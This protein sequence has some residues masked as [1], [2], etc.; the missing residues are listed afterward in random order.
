MTQTDLLLL[1]LLRCFPHCCPEHAPRSYCG[2][3]VHLLVTFSHAVG[4]VNLDELEVCTRFEP[5]R[6]APLWTASLVTVFR[7]AGAVGDD[8]KHRYDNE[9]K[10]KI[11][12]E[13][14][15]PESLFAPRAGQDADKNCVWVRGKRL[16]D[17][18]QRGFPEV[19]DVVAFP[20]L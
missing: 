14:S 17:A 7:S 9:H 15:L 12:E 5:S 10:L 3:S 16:C 20:G 2:C 13:V 4:S 19:N 6:V 1:Q 8:D 11:G 18:E